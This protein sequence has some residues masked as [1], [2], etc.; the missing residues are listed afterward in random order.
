MKIVILCHKHDFFLTEICVASIRY[1]YPEIEIFII[2]DHFKGSFS[3][4]EME[5]VMGVNV[6]DLGIKKFG[7]AA[8][9]MHLLLSDLFPGEKL[10]V[11][12]SDIVFLGRVIDKLLQGSQDYDFA[13]S[14][15]RFDDPYCDWFRGTFYDLDFVNRVDPGFNFP[16]YLFNSGQIVIT[17]GK[18]KYADVADYFDPYHFPY[19]KRRDVFPCVDQSLLNYLIPKK[20]QEN[21]IHVLKTSIMLWSERGEADHIK[22]EKIINANG[23]ESLIHWAGA[24]RTPVLHKMNHAR[25]LQFFQ[26]YYYSKVRYGGIKKVVR[27]SKSYSEYYLRKIYRRAKGV[28]SSAK[29]V[30]IGVLLFCCNQSLLTGFHFGVL[31]L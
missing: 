30:S 12:D 13:V 25:I 9:K 22:L 14:A 20:E 23:Y 29:Q 17:T 11:I 28:L 26:D 10:F 16:G 8:A 19:W 27:G 24:L 4:E 15:D 6:L 3:S 18:L 7:W 5:R 1:F 2:K 31:S 21:E